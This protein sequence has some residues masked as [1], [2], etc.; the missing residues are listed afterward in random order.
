MLYEA[1]RKF[2]PPPNPIIEKGVDEEEQKR[3]VVVAVGAVDA[4]S[5]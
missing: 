3:S 4:D 2:I 1:V 5:D